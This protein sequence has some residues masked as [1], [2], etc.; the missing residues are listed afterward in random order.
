MLLSVQWYDGRMKAVF[1]DRDGTVIVDPPDERVDSIDKIELFPM[2]LQALSELA[3][4]NYSVFFY[5]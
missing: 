4:L 3:E 5:Y 2:T 1:L